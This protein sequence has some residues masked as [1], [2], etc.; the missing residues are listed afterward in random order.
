MDVAAWL[1]NLGLG[2]YEVAFRDGAI[3][4]DVVSRLTAGEVLCA[5][6]ISR[7]LWPPKNGGISMR[8]RAVFLFL[9]ILD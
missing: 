8:L 3:D 4:E 6:R 7:M 9:S 5:Q 1:K 2:Q